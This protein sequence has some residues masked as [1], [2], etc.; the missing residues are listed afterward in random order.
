MGRASSIGWKILRLLRLH[1]WGKFT[2]KPI[3]P[4]NGFFMCYDWFAILCRHICVMNRY[5]HKS[6]YFILTGVGRN[7]S[8]ARLDCLQQKFIDAQFDFLTRVHGRNIVHAQSPCSNKTRGCSIANR[9]KGPLAMC[10]RCPSVYCCSER[11]EDKRRRSHECG[12]SGSWATFRGAAGNAST[13][14]QSK[15][16]IQRSSINSPEYYKRAVLIPYLDGIISDLTDR[17]SPH[18]EA[19]CKISAL[20][21]SHI[22]THCFSDFVDSVRFYQPI[23]K[24]SELDVK[25][26]YDRWV[27]HWKNDTKTL[28]TCPA[29][30]LR[31]CDPKLFPALHDYLTIF[32][33]LPSTSA[34]AERMFSSL[35]YL[36]SYL[37]S[38]TS[39]DRLNGLAR[40]FVHRKTS[41]E[42]NIDRV[43]DLF[44]AK[45]RRLDFLIWYFLF[46]TKYAFYKRY[47]SYVWVS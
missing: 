10:W 8:L 1:S 21:P 15:K 7:I 45:K 40:I 30:A 34:T 26:E 6:V 11:E 17:F 41:A 2:V 32:C 38:T 3:Q 42:I 18:S 39:D 22:K 5:S 33:C 13:R 35:K 31:A 20:I 24:Y 28:P 29:Q 12:S 27:F 37:R 9:R 14:C 4:Q 19:A 23:A 46:S 44:A 47:L 16:Q 36:K 43:I 25:A